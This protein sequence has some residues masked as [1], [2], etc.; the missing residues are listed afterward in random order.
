MSTHRTRDDGGMTEEF[1]ELVAVV[2]GGARGLGAA[3]VRQLSRDGARVAVLDLP[4]AGVEHGVLAIRADVADEAALRVAFEETEV[5]YGQVDILIDTVGGLPGTVRQALP[6]LR[7]FGG[8][9]VAA[10]PLETRSVD[11][12]HA[13]RDALREVTGALAAELA[14]EGIR[15]NCV[16]SGPS[17]KPPSE[18]E[19]E[20]MA[21]ALCWLASPL[22]APT[23][24]SCLDLSGPDSAGPDPTDQWRPP[25]G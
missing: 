15:V 8:A 1:T 21:R 14:V 16:G 12:H 3:V 13:A 22:S 7:R 2:V 24:G 6:W 19:L 4:L 20:R 10:V 5:R 11:S 23:T 9:V 18:R 25:R 17:E